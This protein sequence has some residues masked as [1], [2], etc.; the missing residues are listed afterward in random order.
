[1]TGLKSKRNHK[2]LFQN[3]KMDDKLQQWTKK[4][5]N[6]GRNFAEDI[7]EVVG[8]MKRTVN[9]LEDMVRQL[10]KL[11]NDTKRLVEGSFEKDIDHEKHHHHILKCM[12]CSDAFKN[13]SELEKHIEEKHDEHDT[14]ECETCGKKFVTKFRL[15]KHTKMH[16]NVAIKPCHYF[17]RNQPCPYENLGCKFRH[18]FENKEKNTYGHHVEPCFQ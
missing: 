16:L 6:A 9:V 4:F 18:E 3:M 1:M 14:F 7:L 8:D 17:R 2:M 12:L 5:N 15:E 13:I 10:V 11:E